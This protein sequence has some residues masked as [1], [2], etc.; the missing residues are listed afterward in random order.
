[1]NYQE[2]PSAD[3]RDFS[4]EYQ[5]E[6]DKALLVK[7]FLKPREDKAASAAAG[8]PIFKDVEHVD[9]KIPGNRGSGACRPATDVDRQRFPE[10]Y[11]R[12]KERTETDSMPGTPLHEWPPISRSAAEEL[13]FFNVYTVEQLAG[14][15][16]VQIAKF[17]GLMPLRE[18]AK[19]WLDRAEKDKPMWEL[20]QSIRQLKSEND[21][22]RDAVNNLIAQLENKDDDDV[23]KSTRQR[24]MRNAVKEVR[25]KVE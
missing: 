24:R 21:D 9:I 6:A 12:F 20:D 3:Y 22:L 23:P 19:A 2:L 25:A 5:N 7:F 15:A 10:H 14:M 18:K 13:K 4:P 8:R 1:M 11:R 17:Q 16:D